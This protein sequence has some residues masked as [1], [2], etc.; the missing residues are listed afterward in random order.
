LII[1]LAKI[2]R[3]PYKLNIASSIRSEKSEINATGVNAMSA[4]T[5]GDRMSRKNIALANARP[6]YSPC[7]IFLKC[8]NFSP[9]NKRKPSN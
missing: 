3:A 4:I 5:P 2:T 6:K 1:S 8:P 9:Q 7:T